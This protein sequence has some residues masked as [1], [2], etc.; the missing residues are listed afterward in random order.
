MILVPF[1]P[2]HLDDLPLQVGQGEMVEFVDQEGYADMLATVG[3][4]Y[5]AMVDGTVVAVGGIVPQCEGRCLLWM[6]VS[7]R[8]NGTMMI[9][10][11]RLLKATVEECNFRRIEAI[12][13]CEFTEGK[14]LIEMLGFE[15]ETP[16]GMVNW[17]K[18]GERAYL[19]AC[20][21]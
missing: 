18:N 1:I 6:L 3:D 11:F 9:P 19:Y 12:V 17:F 4:S 14:R 5:S 7:T 15:C 8:L 13:R 21:N 2:A 16:N 10:F 20:S